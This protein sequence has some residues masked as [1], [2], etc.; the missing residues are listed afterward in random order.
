MDQ[1][2]QPDAH[3]PALRRRAFRYVLALV[4]GQIAALAFCFWASM[5][6]WFVYHAGT[7]GLRL[8]GFAQRAA[9][10]ACEV[11]IAGDS[12]GMAAVLPAEIQA[13]TGLKTCN[14][15][16]IRTVEDF[17]GTHLAIDAY[18]AHNPPPR[19]LVTAFGPSDFSLERAHPGSPPFPS[20]IE[21]AMRFDRGPWLWRYM[22]LHPHSTLQFL[23]WVENALI[24]DGLF[25]SIGREKSLYTVDETARRDNAGGAWGVSKPAETACVGEPR[26]YPAFSREENA[27][28]AMAFRKHYETERMHVLIDVTPVTD[29]DPRLPEYVQLTREIPDNVL[30][31]WPVENFNDA[32]IHLAP[33][34]AK[35]FS[36]EVAA[37]ILALMKRDGGSG[38]R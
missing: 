11:V 25:R 30:D 29:C 22:V 36:D 2:E 17:V 34:G 37:Q 18:L 15:S 20:D 10:M 1:L 6:P 14:I 4:L 19:F 9:G 24:S 21:F 23:L 28:G 5:Q 33:E 3:D 16:E 7:S 27:A 35:K 13:R 8:Q 26:F 38:E 32:D 12:T 31:V